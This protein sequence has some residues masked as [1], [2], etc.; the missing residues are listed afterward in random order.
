MVSRWGWLGIVALLAA[1]PGCRSLTFACS[2]DVQCGADGTCELDGW[3]SFPD[4]ACDSGRRYADASGDG[5]GGACVELPMGT[6]TSSE[7]AGGPT[8]GIASSG[9]GEESTTTA[10]SSSTDAVTI[11]GTTDPITTAG[12]SGST[13]TTSVGES[14][15]ASTTEG[16][17]ST[18]E[19]T[20]IVPEAC[21]GISDHFDDGSIDPYWELYGPDGPDHTMEE[22]GSTLRWE[23]TT[24][25]VEQLGIQR[26]LD[27]PFGRTRVHVTD[28]PTLPMAAAQI[29]LTV[30]EYLGDEQYYFVW[31]NGTFEVRDGDT[32]LESLPWVEWVDVTNAEDGLIV[33]ISDDGT[34][35]EPI[36]TLGPGIDIDDTWIVLYGQ[37][38]TASAQPESGAVDFFQI[39]EP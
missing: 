17:S 7:P 5:L 20:G 37:T 21:V 14:S 19:T 33:S 23:F 35:F 24:G 15:T 8:S 22:V 31:S 2:D 16:E 27:T 12:S 38:W 36:V 28:V 30:R 34:D 18:G 11:S 10:T 1:G 4:T 25:V 39:C 6:S 26:V 13:S 29:V 3:C 9:V 32:T